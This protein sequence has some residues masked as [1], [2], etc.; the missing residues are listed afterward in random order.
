MQRRTLIQGM[1]G[2][3]AG[4]AAV[5]ATAATGK[6][7]IAQIGASHAHA[8]GK[9]AA[10]LSLPDLYE[11]AGVSESDAE[12]RAAAEKS[13][14]YA[15][16]PWK[17]ESEILAMADV[18][19]IAVETQVDESA[20]VAMAAIQA[21]KHIHLDKPGALD[22]AAFRALRSTAEAKGLTVQ[23]GYMLRYN[24]AFQL[25]MK[26]VKEGWLGEITEVD[27]MIGKLADASTRGV[28]RKLPG[29][30]MFELG[31]HVIDMVLTLL[32]KP[33][34]VQ[35]FSTPTRAP[36][37]EV[38]DNQMA[39]LVYPKAT[40]VVRCNHAD[41]FG[42]P[43][44]CFRIVGTEGFME[45]EPLESGRG[46]LALKEAR[47]DFKKGVQTFEIPVPKGRY[48]GEF[49]DLAKIVHGEKK[50]AWDAAHDIAVHEA[51]LRA[52]GVFAGM[53]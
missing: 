34:S 50:L 1:A 16:V 8:S 6:I 40:A 19:V 51:V 27:A 23:M 48:D 37:D 41:P 31:C 33:E 47:G 18:S 36:E 20:R 4:L 30:G 21:G 3:V 43:R 52:A 15:G 11:V 7:R 13:A 2:A 49:M 46:T 25:M 39:V 53:K 28:I 17:T 35:A 45:V 44:R 22:H 42:G 38:E 14:A 12:R 9:I 29:G 10:I 32:G 5:D 26:A 24:P